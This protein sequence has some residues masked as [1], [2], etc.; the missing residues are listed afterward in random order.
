MGHVINTAFRDSDTHKIV[1]RTD[2]DSF[3][4]RNFEAHESA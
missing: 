1:Q 3:F 4:G 2:V